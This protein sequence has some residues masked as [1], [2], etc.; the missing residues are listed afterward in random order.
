MKEQIHPSILTKID[1]KQHYLAS[2][3]MIPQGLMGDFL[4]N[5]SKN[6]FTQCALKLKRHYSKDDI[7]KS[8]YKEIKRTYFQ[9]LKKTT[10]IEQQHKKQLETIVAD[11]VKEVFNAHDYFYEINLE[12]Q[13][14]LDSA[15]E[16]E[17]RDFKDYN[18]IE[19]YREKNNREQF[20]YALAKGAANNFTKLFVTKENEI[21]ML[22]HRLVDCYHKILAFNDFNIWV[23]P[24][25]IFDEKYVFK[26]YFSVYSQQEYNGASSKTLYVYAPSFLVALNQA[27]LGV[28]SDYLGISASM[29]SIVKDCAWNERI[30]AVVHSKI[31]STIKNPMSQKK[32]FNDIAKL[33]GPAMKRLFNECL[34]GTQFHNEKIAARY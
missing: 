26:K 24:D 6:I 31:A 27:F 17:K 12:E 16:D 7:T 18:E 19:Q 10:T 20:L 9:L 28:V 1:N 30:G 21:D 2:S 8:N 13:D 33:S 5:E 4:G 3:E 25:D 29:S 23:T 34:M 14:F 22:D 11:I 32:F 15:I